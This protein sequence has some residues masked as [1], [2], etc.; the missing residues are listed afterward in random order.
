MT[1]E[2]ALNIVLIVI[3]TISIVFDIIRIVKGYTLEKEFKKLK[4]QFD[5]LTAGNHTPPDSN[6]PTESDG[7][8]KV[9][10]E[11]QEQAKIIISEALATNKDVVILTKD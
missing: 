6:I 3:L 1:A 5:S 9:S 8:I 2:I 7:K 10:L 4:A 11:N